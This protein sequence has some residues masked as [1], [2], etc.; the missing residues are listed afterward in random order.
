MKNNGGINFDTTNIAGLPAPDQIMQHTNRP[1]ITQIIFLYLL[2]LLAIFAVARLVF[3]EYRFLNYPYQ[4]ELREGLQFN[5]GILLSEEKSIYALQQDPPVVL[6]PYGPVNPV[7]LSGVMRVFG[8]K[9]FAAR[10]LSFLC[11]IALQMLMAYAVYRLTRRWQ[12]VLIAI[13]LNT[14]LLSWVQWL[15]LCRPDSLGSLLLFA[16]LCLHWVHPYRKVAIII[17]LLLIVLSFFTKVYFAM[18]LMFVPVSYWFFYRDRRTALCYFFSGAVLLFASMGIANHLTNGL[19][20]F[21]TF[22]LMSKWV[23]YSLDHLLEMFKSLLAYF[24]PLF[25]LILYALIKKDF[26]YDALNVFWI[27]IVIGI[28]IFM[29]LLLNAGAETYYWYGIIPAL[30]LVGMDVLYRE[31]MKEKS[32]LAV[33]MLIFLFIIMANKIVY[34]DMIQGKMIFPS[35]HLSRQWQPVD[36]LFAHTKGHVIND[37]ATTTCALRAGK[38]LYMEGLG[39]RKLKDSIAKQLNYT[40][41]DTDS[42]IANQAYTLIINPENESY[43]KQY[44]CLDHTYTVPLQLGKA[45]H[46]KIYAPKAYSERKDESD[47]D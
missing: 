35:E 5:H 19:Y 17:S 6:E 42:E 18:G 23:T 41:R 47:S 11:F 7:L 38:R 3:F 29:F 34:S 1:S 40:F 9:L 43:V 45:Y 21:F 26:R 36:D 44:Y 10:L 31:C 24:F 13:G 20:H 46:L 4:W 37:N 32:P 14:F 8:K 12:F 15:L 27:Q 22:E 25:V 2:V 33:T 30:T 39:Y 28:P 16:T